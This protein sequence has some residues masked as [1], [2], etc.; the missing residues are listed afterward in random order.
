MHDRDIAGHEVGELCE[1]QGWTQIAHQALIE[2]GAGIVRGAQACQNADINLS[3]TFAAPCRNDHVG[4]RE[5][6]GIAFHAR[7]LER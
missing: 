4:A 7:A 5:Q 6:V 3:V 1:K 2:I